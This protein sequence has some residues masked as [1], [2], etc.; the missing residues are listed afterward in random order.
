MTA[1][2]G[3][4][5]LPT[6][7]GGSCIGVFFKVSDAL[8]CPLFP[9][10]HRRGMLRVSEMSDARVDELKL[11]L[12]QCLLADWVR[13]GSRLVRVLR[14]RHHADRHNALIDRLLERARASV[15]LRQWRAENLPRPTYPN[16][17]P[18]T[19]K[20]DEILQAIRSR[21]VVVVAGETGSGKTTQ[22]PKICLE[23]GFGIE[24]KI[25]CTQPRRVAALSISQAGGG[26]IGVGWSRE[27]DARS[28]S[29]TGRESGDV[30]QIHDRRH[31]A[32]RD[33]GRSVDLSEYNAIVLD[34]AH[35][36]SL[37]IDFLLGHLKTLL[38][39]ARRPEAPDHVG[40]HRHGGILEGLRRRAGGR[41]LGP[42]V[43]VEVHYAP[44]AA[45]GSE[46]RGES[47]VHRC[48]GAGGG[49]DPCTAAGR[50]TS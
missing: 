38:P 18:I 49:A 3:A 36:R 43:P 19:A 45:A 20:K 10:G 31:A 33:A 25:G 12:P 41:G 27:S 17:L 42:D 7:D 30:R 8:H 44:I 35:E 32:G 23:A 37:N 6:K 5:A 39:K 34:E 13:L 40:D 15:A 46:E 2:D 29:T 28:G 24:A 47:D 26:G 4:I 14:D 22:I 48:G 50:A 21:Q 11:L 16:E 1:L 9:S